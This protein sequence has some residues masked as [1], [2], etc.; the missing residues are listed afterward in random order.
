MRVLGGIVL[1]LWGCQTPAQYWIKIVHPWVQKFYP[2]LGLRS[3]LGSYGI[4]RLQFCTVDFWGYFWVFSGGGGG[5]KTPNF[6]KVLET[7]FCDFGPESLETPVKCGS[8][9]KP[10]SPASMRRILW[11]KQ[12]RLAPERQQC[13]TARPF[14]A[15]WRSPEQTSDPKPSNN[16]EFKSE[17]ALERQTFLFRFNFLL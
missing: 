7:V 12:Q 6:L 9:R 14:S 2:V 10:S 4:S 3:L 15:S 1:A 5:K 13:N 8:G 16:R 17:N 11:K